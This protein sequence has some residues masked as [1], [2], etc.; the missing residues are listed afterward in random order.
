MIHAVV[1]PGECLSANCE[2]FTH[3]YNCLSPHDKL[4]T[5]AIFCVVFLEEKNAVENLLLCLLQTTQ[6]VIFEK[7]RENMKGQ[8]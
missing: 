3:F 1:R 4:L 2:G 8:A 5:T 7:Q 6:D